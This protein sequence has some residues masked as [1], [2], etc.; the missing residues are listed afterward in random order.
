[1]AANQIGDF[2]IR[3]VDVLRIKNYETGELIDL[4]KHLKTT[5]L[6]NTGEII[7]VNGGLKNKKIHSYTGSKESKITFTNATNKLNFLAMQTG[8][9]IVS[10]SR[11]VD[12]T[13]TK[14]IAS[15]KVTL[16]KTI[17]ESTVPE[18]FVGGVK[19]TKGTSSPSSN[20]FTF[21]GQDVTF[22]K[23]FEGKVATVNFVSTVTET[24]SIKQSGD[25][26]SLTCSL[27]ADLLLQDVNTKK[28]FIG[29]L[30]AKSAKLSEDFNL[31]AAQ[32]GEP[33]A[34]SLP[35]DLNEVDGYPTWE[36][37]IFAN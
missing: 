13:E 9:A 14:V 10:G 34:I 26:E 30:S 32:E 22:S 8:S 17:K 37:T 18:V 27:T 1:M 7:N 23:E 25:N 16:G 20:E 31:N 21:S 33:E 11:D 2:I 15:N 3:G 35:F 12:V 29:Q 4:I 6:E 24:E 19:L 5:G 36:L 28:G